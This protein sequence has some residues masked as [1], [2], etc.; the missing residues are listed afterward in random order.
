[1]CVC[2]VGAYSISHYLLGDCS[3]PICNII[4]DPGVEIDN[5]ISFKTRIHNMV[6]KAIQRIYLIWRFLSKDITCLSK[7]FPVFVRV[8]SLRILFVHLEAVVHILHRLCR[9]C[10]TSLYKQLAEFSCMPYR[11]H[12]KRLKLDTLELCRSNS[13]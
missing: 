2:H 8:S 6:Y 12:L 7:T 5:L 13:N 10:S 11:E 1:M 3:L 4:S 9:I